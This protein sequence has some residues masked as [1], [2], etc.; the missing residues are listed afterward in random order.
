MNKKSGNIIFSI[1]NGLLEQTHLHLNVIGE[2]KVSGLCLK[3][4]LE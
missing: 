2:I 1:K 3:I 4:R